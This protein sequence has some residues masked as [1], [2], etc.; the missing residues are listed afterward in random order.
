VL[1]ALHTRCRIIR[2]SFVHPLRY[3]PASYLYA[4]TPL[5][6]RTTFPRANSIDDPDFLFELKHDG[7]RALAHIWDGRCELILRKR[8]AYKS[9]QDLRDNLA[10]LK[11]QNAERG[12]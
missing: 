6:R 7:F 4:P 2:L 12:D 9:F 1:V 5:R 11:V 8:N 3:L 10:K